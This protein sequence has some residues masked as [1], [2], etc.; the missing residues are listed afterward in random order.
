VTVRVLD[1]YQHTSLAQDCSEKKL[2]VASW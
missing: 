1:L 2:V